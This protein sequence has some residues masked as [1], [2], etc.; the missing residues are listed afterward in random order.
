MG[1]GNLCALL[2]G[3]KT[4]AIPMDN[5]MDYMVVLVLTFYIFLK[6]IIQQFHFLIFISR[7]WKKNELQ[8]IMKPH[9]HFSI[10]YNSPDM[11]AT[12]SIKEWINKE[13]VVHTHTTHTHTEEYYSVFLKKKKTL[14]STTTWM[15]LGG[16]T[17]SETSHRYKYLI[18]SLI[19]RI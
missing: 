4:G 12:L 9:V 16:I 8:D 2:V 14:P 7:K 10:I 17:L 15:D 3:M 18:I 11:E 13:N 19:C 6:N 5:N 1:K